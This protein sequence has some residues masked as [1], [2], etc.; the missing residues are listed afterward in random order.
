MKEV[1]REY[2]Y[3]DEGEKKYPKILSED[4]TRV[5]GWKGIVRGKRW[6]WA[7]EDFSR[8]S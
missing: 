4:E 1:T 6:D 3:T 5:V 2:L 8:E 7:L